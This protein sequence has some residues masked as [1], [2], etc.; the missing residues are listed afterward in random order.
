M[1]Y[2]ELA[3]SGVSLFSG[4]HILFG[5]EVRIRVPRGDESI[6]ELT[7]LLDALFR[8]FKVEGQIL[9]TVAVID[10]FH[11]SLDRF[12]FFGHQIA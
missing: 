7:Q 8:F 2:R 5:G 6:V 3:F 1:P 11:D 12:D 4:A 9:V 10:V